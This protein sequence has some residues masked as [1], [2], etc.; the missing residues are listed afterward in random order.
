MTVPYA[1]SAA[2]SAIPLSQLDDNFN[3]T[4]TLGNTAIQLGNTVTTLNNMTLANVTISSGNVT[5]TNVTVTTANVTTVNATTV[6]ATTANVTTG[7]VTNLISGNVSL[8]GGSITGTPISGS[9][10]S[11]TTL[12]TSSTVTL[13]GGTAGGVAYLNGSKAL[14]TGSALTFDGNNL[15]IGANGQVGSRL[16]VIANGA[17]ATFNTGAAADG[18]IEYAYNGTNIFYTGVNSAS[19]MMLMARSGVELGFGA[20]NAEQMR[21]TSTGLGIGT[22][23]PAQKLGVAGNAI[24]SGATPYISLAYNQSGAT[25]NYWELSAGGVATLYNIGTGTNGQWRFVGGAGTEHMRLDSS[26]NL[27]LGTTSPASNGST[28]ATLSLNGSN[29]GA[30]HFMNAGTTVMQLYNDANAFFLNAASGKQTIFQTA[31]T[32]R[33]RIDSSGNLLVGTTSAL[34]SASGRGNITVNGTDAVLAFGNS[35]SSAGYIYAASTN[36]ELSAAST[37][38]INFLTNGSERARITSGGYFKASNDGTYVS[39]TGSYHEFTQT[40][41]LDTFIVRNTNA[42]LTNP[43]FEANASRNTT[44]NSFYPI[45]YYNAGATVYRFRVAD[46][47]DVTNTNNSYGAI[48]DVKTK[49]DIV[50]AASQWDDLKGLRVR[51][52]RYKNDPTAPLQI[53]LVAQEAETVSPGLIDEHPDYEEVEVTD[54]EGNVKTERQLTGTSTKSIKYSVLYMKAIKALQEAMARI[55]TLEAKVAAL[56]GTQP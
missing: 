18:R 42:S 16:T 41:N 15:S 52:F 7:N 30:L 53:G 1:F 10:G 4:I 25:P 35:N 47:G 33:A 13:N 36:L 45:V 46:S 14:T 2:T 40:Q 11:F 27:G 24:F 43:V 28:F 26:G 17:M 54:E 23:S 55:E 19:L 34:T 22:S 50:D 37:R 44:N 5:I 39:S 21:L 32:E 20:N 6:I 3:T 48:S 8:T 31:S 56:E 49:Q 38:Y 12:T 9:T 51:K 29:G